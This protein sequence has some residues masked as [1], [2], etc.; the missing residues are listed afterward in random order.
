MTLLTIFFL[1]NIF[2]SIAII[3]LQKYKNLLN[4]KI[5]YTTFLVNSIFIRD[6]SQIPEEVYIQA[7]FFDGKSSP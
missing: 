7:L 6:L 1:I 4:K 5:T 3:S 2:E